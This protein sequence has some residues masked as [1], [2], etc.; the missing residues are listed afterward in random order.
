M[1]GLVSYFQNNQYVFNGLSLFSHLS[2]SKFLGHDRFFFVG[3]LSTIKRW[4]TVGVL[5]LC[6]R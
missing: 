4:K 2:H 3:H 5:Y 1:C 6:S